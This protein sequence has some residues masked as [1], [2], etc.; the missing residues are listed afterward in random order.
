MKNLIDATRSLVF[1]LSPP[2]LHELGFE[3][4]VEWLSEL[5]AEMHGLPC[6][7]E[8]RGLPRRMAPDVEVSLFQAVREALDNT[9]KHAHAAHAHI[10]LDWSQA[11]GLVV[12]V[13]DDGCGFDVVE[14][15][16]RRSRAR[17]F[18]LFSMRERLGVLGGRAEVESSHGRGTRVRLEMPEAAVGPAAKA[19]T[20]EASLTY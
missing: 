17:G 7:V 12:S 16:S 15:E 11:G 13:E 6:S 19:E 20:F 10:V 9:A 14:V 5:I 8:S 4:A 1:E 3:A 2:V 18:G